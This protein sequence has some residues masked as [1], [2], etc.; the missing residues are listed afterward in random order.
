MDDRFLALRACRPPD[1]AVEQQEAADLGAEDDDTITMARA[2]RPRP[3]AR[4]RASRTIE[5]ARGHEEWYGSR[6]SMGR[7]RN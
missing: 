3:P 2:Y 4:A 6:R 1:G 5:R 7:N